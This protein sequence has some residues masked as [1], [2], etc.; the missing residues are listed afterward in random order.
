MK[1]QIV[2]TLFVT[3]LLLGCSQTDIEQSVSTDIPPQPTVLLEQEGEEELTPSDDIEILPEPDS[4]SSIVSEE[5]DAYLPSLDDFQ[6]PYSSMV[7]PILNESLV[8]NWGSNY[9]QILDEVERLDGIGCLYDLESTDANAPTRILVVIERF[10]SVEG[11]TAFFTYDFPDDFRKGIYKGNSIELGSAEGA[12]LATVNN[13]NGDDPNA[14]NVTVTFR[15]K[16]INAIVEGQGT[17]DNVT[18]EYLEPIALSILEKL[19]LSP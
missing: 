5:L 3:L 6:D 15:Y 11:S 2:L 9:Q 8:D 17:V 10:A 7:F 12:I 18:F 1:K 13:P 14:L 4:A 16:N 19:E